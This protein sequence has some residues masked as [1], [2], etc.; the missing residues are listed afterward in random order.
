MIIRYCRFI[1]RNSHI[2]FRDA[3]KFRDIVAHKYESLKMGDVY[4]T[5]KRDFL[6]M[7][8]Q[9]KQVLERL[10]SDKTAD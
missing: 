5:M 2:E 6:N 9:I 8:N 7:K 3:A 10:E 1:S 4:D